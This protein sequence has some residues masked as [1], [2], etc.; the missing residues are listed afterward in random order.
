M[1][2]LSR[3]R[4]IRNQGQSMP[5]FFLDPAR[6]LSAG[7]SAAQQRPSTPT[8]HRSISSGTARY[9]GSRAWAYR[10]YVAVS[11]TRNYLP[12]PSHPP[13]AVQMLQ[14]GVDPLRIRTTHRPGSLPRAN[15]IN[16]RSTNTRL[17]RGMPLGIKAPNR[18]YCSDYSYD[19]RIY[20]KQPTSPP[21]PLDKR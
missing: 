6:A 1:P 7:S 17:A 4:T 14:S 5:G 12:M 2:S 13:I 3:E 16:K 19:E 10:E 21:P 11:S 18:A 9:Q 15:E 8:S 20:S